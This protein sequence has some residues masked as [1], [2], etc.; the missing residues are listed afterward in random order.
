[1]RQLPLGMRWRDGSV[2]ETF[3]SGPNEQAVDALRHLEWN[4]GPALW[5]WGP[6]ATGKTHLLQASCAR[7][8]AAGRTAAYFPMSQYE[9]FDPGALAGCEQLDLVCIDD[10]HSVAG[11]PEWERSLFVL[12]N[13]MQENQRRLVLASS[14]APAAVDWRLADLGSRMSAS[15]VFQLRGLSEEEQA[16]VL[17][18]RARARGLELQ[19]EAAGYLLRRLPRDLRSLCELLEK[20]DTASLAAN[21][22]LTVPFIREVL[23]RSTSQR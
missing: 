5:L 7:A 12:Y 14:R 22:R 8:G 1:M 18:V 6:A 4:A 10:V 21:R 19:E 3:V 13:A 16:D 23:E 20:L 15:L 11:E 9:Q 17:R 2:F